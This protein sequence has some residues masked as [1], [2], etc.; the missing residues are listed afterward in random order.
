M[1]S[2]TNQ[3]ND[4]LRCGLGDGAWR[5]VYYAMSA[6]RQMR[7]RDAMAESSKSTKMLRPSRT[8]GP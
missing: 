2:I 1:R 6:F 4:R 7:N 8:T 5:R 3:A